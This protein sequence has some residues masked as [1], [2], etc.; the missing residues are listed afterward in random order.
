MQELIMNQ[1]HVSL[2]YLFEPKNVKEAINDE[3]WVKVMKEELSQ[4]DK[5]ETWE[6]VPRPI[7][8]NVIGAK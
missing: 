1:E 7:N 6:L 8:K 3:H 4:I 5:N 2:I